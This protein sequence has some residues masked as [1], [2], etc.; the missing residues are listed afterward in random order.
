MNEEL[1]SRGGLSIDRL[2]ALVAVADA[3]GIARAAPR[4]PIRQSQLSRQI[5]ELEELFG[6][7]L[8]Q[9]AGRSI[10]LTD[11]GRELAAVSRAMISGLVDVARAAAAS[12]VP[13]SLGAGDSVLHWW[14]L[15]R[16]GQVLARVPGV[17]LSL[18]ALSQ[19][20]LL[21]RVADARLDL[22]L[23]RGEPPLGLER[24]RVGRLSFALFVPR[25][26]A[27]APLAELPW[28]L[29]HSEP[30][31]NEPLARVLARSGGPAARL[32][33]ETFPQV[34][35]AVAA[36][37]FAGLLPELAAGELRDARVLSLPR[38]LPPPAD[39]Y[40]VWRPRTTRA[41]ARAAHFSEALGEA[42]SV[43]ARSTKGS[44]AELA[45]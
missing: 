10:A 17:E 34:C 33:C 6:C 13:L 41:R 23:V 39:V 24:R 1:F 37:R 38:S 25:R 21:Q 7:Q 11:V 20:E 15:P 4:D 43:P 2:R 29:Q 3:G 18:V 35:R 12:P 36:G 19:P 32:H 28:A 42:L 14:V 9:R 27:T 44:A 40:L 16:L 30:A 31:L 8:V 45:P 5:G 26:L 22:A